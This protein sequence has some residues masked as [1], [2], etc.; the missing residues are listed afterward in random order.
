MKVSAMC[1]QSNPLHIIHV[2]RRTGAS[3]LGRVTYRKKSSH[4]AVRDTG[5]R[6]PVT[7]RSATRS[8]S[9]AS[10]IKG[11]RRGPCDLINNGK[12]ASCTLSPTAGPN[13]SEVMLYL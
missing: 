12:G 13:G 6:P 9:V 5:M 7:S 11:I 3:S 4:A 10:A 8:F 1:R 2:V